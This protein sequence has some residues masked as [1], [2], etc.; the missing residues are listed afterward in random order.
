MIRKVILVIIFL[1]PILLFCQFNK[2]KAYRNSIDFANDKPLYQTTFRYVQIKSAKAH[3]AYKV[4]SDNLVI[5]G[6]DMKYSIWVISDGEYLYL[7]G[8]RNGCIDGYIRLKK[9]SNYNY[10]M[11]EPMLSNNQQER[12]NNSSILFGVV[13]ATITSANIEKETRGKEHHVLDLSSGKTYT[14]TKDYIRSLLAD[15]PLLLNEFDNT[16]NKDDLEILKAYLERINQL[17]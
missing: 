15:Y 16:E 8:T 11:A 5:S 17:Y 4:K 14:L 7:N 10:F 9:G 1:N 3:G 2:G 12:L 6:H 13:G